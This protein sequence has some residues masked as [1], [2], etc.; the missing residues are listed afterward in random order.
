MKRENKELLGVTGAAGGVGCL[1]CIGAVL[2]I[3]LNLA[4]IAG[5]VWVAVKVLQHTGVL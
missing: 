3:A 5:G 2:G 4:M 1:W